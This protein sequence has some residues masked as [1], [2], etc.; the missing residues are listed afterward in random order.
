M[1]KQARVGQTE[2]KFSDHAY[3]ESPLGITLGKIL[4]AVKRVKQKYSNV[5]E[6][7]LSRTHADDL[8]NFAQWAL[9]VA[10]ENVLLEF[11]RGNLTP[12]VPF[13]P[14]L[15]KWAAEVY[16][17]KYLFSTREF[18]LYKS[19]IALIQK[20]LPTLIEKNQKK[21][22]DL[23]RQDLLCSLLASNKKSLYAEAEKLPGVCL[24]T[25]FSELLKAIKQKKLFG[26][27][28]EVNIEQKKKK[29]TNDIEEAMKKDMS[30]IEEYL[31]GPGAQFEDGCFSFAHFHPMFFEI[32][33]EIVKIT[34]ALP[35]QLNKVVPF[36]SPASIDHYAKTV[37]LVSALETFK[38]I[39]HYHFKHTGP[40]HFKGPHD[41]LHQYQLLVDGPKDDEES[42]P[43]WQ[44]DKTIN[45]SL[46]YNSY[47]D[48]IYSML[49]TRL[50]NYQKSVPANKAV[51]NAMKSL[52]ET[53]QHHYTKTKGSDDFKSER[54]RALLLKRYTSVQLKHIQ[55]VLEDLPK[56][57]E[58]FNGLSDLNLIIAL[59]NV[60]EREHRK[61]Q[62]YDALLHIRSNLYSRSFRGEMEVLGD[63]ALIPQLS[64]DKSSGCDVSYAD[65]PMP[66]YMFDLDDDGKVKL[67][68]IRSTLRQA[69][70][71]KIQ[72][73]NYDE[74]IEY[75]LTEAR[76]GAIAQWVNARIRECAMSVKDFED[77]I[78]LKHKTVV[79]LN[80]QR[81][82]KETD[83]ND[84]QSLESTLAELEQEELALLGIKDFVDSLSAK[85]TALLDVP[86]R[87]RS[88]PFLVDTL[89]RTV[90][91]LDNPTK[92][93]LD[94]T[95]SALISLRSERKDLENDLVLAREKAE[96]KAQAEAEYAKN[97]AAL[98][99]V[100]LER[101][102]REESERSQA[103]SLC[104][105]LLKLEYYETV[106]QLRTINCEDLSFLRDEQQN[107]RAQIE[108]LE[109]TTRSLVVEAFEKLTEVQ[110][111]PDVDS[112]VENPA[113]LV[114]LLDASLRKVEQRCK[115]PH[116]SEA[117]LATL[118]EV[119]RIVSSREYQIDIRAIE[120]MPDI[121]K[122]A[123][124]LMGLISMLSLEGAEVAEWQQYCVDEKD[125]LTF[126]KKTRR[127]QQRNK[128]FNQLEAKIA[129]LNS[130]IQSESEKD[131][132]LRKRLREIKEQLQENNKHLSLLK[133]QSKL[134]KEDIELRGNAD[135]RSQLQSSLKAL[136]PCVSLLRN[137]EK[138]RE[139]I[140]AFAASEAL[141]SPHSSQQ[142]MLSNLY[143]E[144]VGIN[145]ILGDS[146][147]KMQEFH[148]LVHSPEYQ[149]TYK[150]VA[151]NIQKLLE[152][153]T[154]KFNDSIKD[155]FS[156]I[157]TDL[158][159]HK[160]NIT[161]FKDKATEFSED[162]DLY[163]EAL[164]LLAEQ[165][166]LSG[167][168]SKLRQIIQANDDSKNYQTVLAE[169]EDSLQ[170]LPSE[171]QAEIDKKFDV[172]VSTLN[173]WVQGIQAQYDEVDSLYARSIID[174]NGFTPEII[175]E[176][177]AKLAVSKKCLL[178]IQERYNAVREVNRHVLILK[179]R[180]KSDRI[181]E[182]QNQ[183]NT[184]NQ[185]LIALQR[186]VMGAK[187]LSDLSLKFGQYQET[188]PRLNSGRAGYITEFQQLLLEVAKTR[189]CEPVIK[190]LKEGA[191]AYPGTRFGQLLN[192]MIVEILDFTRCGHYPNEEAFPY[193]DDA[194]KRAQLIGDDQSKRT[195]AK[196]Y[197]NLAQIQ[198][199]ARKELRGDMAQV[200]DQLTIKLRIDL[201]RFIL[202]HQPGEKIS[203]QE[204]NRFRDTFIARLHTQDLI[205][206][207]YK[208]LWAIAASIAIMVLTLGAQPLYSMY[209]GGGALFFEDKVEVRKQMAVMENVVRKERKFISPN[210]GPQSQ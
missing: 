151:E 171:I 57:T 52:L 77:K 54:A 167:V 82:K 125:S 129:D 55:S 7:S 149:K 202:K 32:V 85:K 14:R 148:H 60:L 17:N 64:T 83:S 180:K 61:A 181:F 170:S 127:S 97:M 96:K 159:A 139:R 114:E 163:G 13:L 40:S 3:A 190:K 92:K 74:A 84:I 42:P 198:N 23:P 210:N 26:D 95:E 71:G 31:F 113:I 89:K 201:D 39:S 56:P 41:V 191:R 103:L 25:F 63:A 185:K 109:S 155:K 130:T 21:L 99:I 145:K 137:I 116:R 140:D 203:P 136:H 15:I 1:Q 206:K 73:L 178:S 50:V 117:S 29:V 183:L 150:I 46:E 102:L 18:T 19:A 107:Y 43:V 131:A 126:V 164:E 200:V 6:S 138:L 153:M 88:F 120:E 186:G 195:F 2:K 80:T 72:E 112:S 51:Q 49:L 81:K 69:V 98:N 65:S 175:R 28:F 208:P 115:A 87:A 205:I 122:E 48:F 111:K 133:L 44:I 119:K 76:D 67:V 144:V 123:K 194:R 106:E 147:K 53:V 118:L 141:F 79:T 27:A 58:D 184:L 78:E 192:Q 59:D 90:E 187:M 94:L 154:R 174:G 160:R 209:H 193:H 188:H 11:D 143:S 12:S 68:P 47:F 38:I 9:E 142:D 161:E 158:R 30:Y 62:K 100:S 70:D 197:D 172:T 37:P 75:K 16:W 108:Q 45:A 93:L 179:D 5:S 10:H 20:E 86:E 91:C 162:K 182:V 135:E 132:A 204:Y 124:G 166:R 101:R 157:E 146:Q 24:D 199:F 105:E 110:V 177:D 121:K 196:L 156:H 176:I 22:R 207:Q 4:E 168:V 173:G 8:L 36:L 134:R 104:E 169:I 152:S 34:Y 189:E 35:R 33:V 128:L 66:D 165:D